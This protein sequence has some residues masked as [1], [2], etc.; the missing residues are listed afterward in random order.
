MIEWCLPCTKTMLKDFDLKCIFLPTDA[1]ACGFSHVTQF[2]SHRSWWPHEQI[3][4]GEEI[5]VKWKW[6]VKSQSL[7]K[8]IV[9]W[10][11]IKHN[12][13]IFLT[14]Q[15]HSIKNSDVTYIFRKTVAAN[16]QL[17]A[18]KF[19]ISQTMDRLTV[20]FSLM[21]IFEVF[22]SEV[23]VPDI[24]IH[25]TMLIIKNP[26]F[27]QSTRNVGAQKTCWATNIRV[28]SIWSA[29]KIFWNVSVWDIRL[30]EFLKK[31]I[32]CKLKVYAWKCSPKSFDTF[33]KYV[34][35]LISYFIKLS[36][37]PTASDHTRSC[38]I[39]VK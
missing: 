6:V 38:R 37:S 14:W 3:Q 20:T 28:A 24:W 30:R 23:F 19:S 5:I 26:C 33:L 27:R 18:G 17:N 12:R 1:R 29:A 13:I 2:S 32:S 34:L 39:S 21:S 8:P 10:W 31:G 7:M 16:S 11:E 4:F 15:S 25:F 9:K 35:T 36:F 22:T